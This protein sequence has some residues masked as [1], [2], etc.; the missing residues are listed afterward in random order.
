MA[1]FKKRDSLRLIESEIQAAWEEHKVFEAEVD[2]SKEHYLVTFP[3]PYMN[4]RLHLGHAFTMLKADYMTAYQ[5]LLGKN[6]LFPYA[7]HC[8]G[9]P[10]Q[11]AAT[12][13]QIE[14][15]KYGVPP[16]AAAVEQTIEGEDETVVKQ[17]DKFKGAKGKLAKKTG[18]AKLQWDILKMVGIP[19]DE[20]PRF[21]DPVYWLN[22]FPRLG[23][24]DLKKLGLHVDWRRSFITT[25]E[26]QYY[27]KFIRW[28]FQKL[29][30]ADKVAFGRRPTVYSP[31][32]KQACADHDRSVGEGVGPQEYT[33]IKIQTLELKPDTVAQ[34]PELA[35]QVEAGKAFL[36]AATLRPETMY[37][38]TNCFLLPDGEYGAFEI[39]STGEVFICSHRS[40]RNMSYQDPFVATQ[41]DIRC[42]AT[43]TGR[44]L[45][46]LPVKAPKTSYDKVYT[47]PLLTISMNKGT[48][49]VTSV[50]SDAP[51]DYAA[52]RDWQND[53]KLR[54]KY[55]IT[56]EMVASYQVIPII[57]IPG[58]G[59]TCAV[60]MCDKL[61]IKSQ[62]DSKKLADAKAE[63]YK[64][65][66]YEGVMIVGEE[67]GVKGLKVC[68]A[69]DMVKNIMIKDGEAMVYYEPEKEVVS[70]SG[71]SCVVSYLD[72]WFIKYGEEKWRDEVLAHVT[73]PTKFT[74]YTDA[75]RHEFV[76]ILHWLKEWACSRSFGLGTNLPWDE[77]FVIESLSDSTIYMAYYTISHLLQGRS[78][79]DDYIG[80]EGASPLD[81]KPEQLTNEAFD[82][83]FLKK[84]YPAGCEIE[85]SKLDILRESFEY[86]Y[87]VNLRVSGK[88]LVRNHL[89]MCLY[90]HN[91]VWNDR[92]D[93]MPK[94]FFV[95]GTFFLLCC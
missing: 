24:Q 2:A 12:K 65:G 47:L 6:V 27:D 67:D 7:F 51:D 39:P 26:N 13:L 16:V 15:Q 58:M 90:N 74:G 11:G 66:F 87:P 91:A 1:Q 93:L 4:G 52:L 50:P 18:S 31:L 61:K 42:I 85:Q 40:A 32:D 38:Q 21:A 3:Y 71:D 78:S 49:V 35:R 5:R 28:Q 55:G 73:D 77:Q 14:M 54:N 88:D 75:T 83:I 79:P 69:K 45:I 70:R 84:S 9:M 48:G 56:E 23:E 46:G 36:V 30:D 37:G 94:S 63:T 82:Y 68:D 64:K 33:L 20:I 95:N 62:N 43:V 34:N 53:G 60:Y 81:I 10:I 29:R 41:G 17:L 80:N 89:T 86:W 19:D 72:Q 92:P 8:T 25:S 44:E 76:S 57:E 59:N 22:Y